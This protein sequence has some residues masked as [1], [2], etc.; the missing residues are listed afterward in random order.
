[1]AVSEPQL[2]SRSSLGRLGRGAV[3]TAA[4]RM[5]EDTTSG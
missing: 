5:V 3:E 4:G 2:E 1:M